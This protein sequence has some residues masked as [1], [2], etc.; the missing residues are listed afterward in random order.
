MGTLHL[1]G[2]G[3]S[4]GV[5]L[6]LAVQRR[7]ACWDRI[8]LLDDDP[9]RLGE[10]KLGVE[11]IGPL[12]LLH[13]A[14]PRTDEAVNLVAR[15]TAGRRAVRERIRASGI[16]FAPLVAADV[17]LDGAEVA[18]DVI[19]YQ[20]ATIGP[21]VVV[22]AGSVVFMGAVVGHEA[23]VGPGCVIA[24]NA[25]LNARVT[26]GEGTYVGS[27]ATIV[28]EVTVGE[29]ARVGAG[30]LVVEDV[31]DGASVLGVP[32]ELLSCA[33]PA[34]PT[35]RTAAA[36][37]SLRDVERVVLDAWRGVLGAGA[38]DREA[39]FFDAGG[40]SL[41]A[42]QLRDRIRREGGMEMALTDVF[43][44]P[45]VRSLAEHLARGRVLAAGAGLGRAE[46]RRMARLQARGWARN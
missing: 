27:C 45:T 35:D 38:V 43:R 5:R 36:G 12:S 2:A 37:T 21:E 39:N 44:F 15:T 41:H 42:L 11:V 18:R 40:C 32:A 4:E 14:D 13:E 19:V 7:A 22:Q 26:L 24:S 20:H 46:A 30:S 1:C 31:P 25:V 33:E 16:P 10:V 3:N 6:A 9:A 34:C 28:P 8:V 17:D 29:W 23:R